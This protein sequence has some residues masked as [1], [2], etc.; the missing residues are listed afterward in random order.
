ML[1]ELTDGFEKSQMARHRASDS[2][3]GRLLLTDWG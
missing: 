3:F 1:G 2:V